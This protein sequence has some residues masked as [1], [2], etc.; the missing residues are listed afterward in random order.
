[1][2][3]LYLVCGFEFEGFDESK[4]EFRTNGVI[5]YD[6]QVTCVPSMFMYLVLGIGKFAPVS[7][8]VPYVW[9]R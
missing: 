6:Y 9:R 7:R 8:M 5:M 1:M 2:L 3:V 4:V